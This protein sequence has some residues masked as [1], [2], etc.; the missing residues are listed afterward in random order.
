MKRIIFALSA[1]ACIA[2]LSACGGTNAPATNAQAYSAGYKYGDTSAALDGLVAMVSDGASLTISS[3][4]LYCQVASLEVKGGMPRKW[5]GLG[6]VS[7]KLAS[8]WQSGCI[9][10]IRAEAKASTP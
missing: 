1:V 7:T 9:D 4:K 6:A 8:E 2:G 5:L 10:G 3:M